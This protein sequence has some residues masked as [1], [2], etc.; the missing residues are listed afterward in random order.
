MLVPRALWFQVQQT[1][2]LLSTLG[3]RLWNAAAGLRSLGIE[4]QGAQAQLIPVVVREARAHRRLYRV[5]GNT[6]Q[7]RRIPL[8]RRDAGSSAGRPF[9]G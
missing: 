6:D 1:V 7:G 8:A 4:H 2:L 3:V 9:S 5:V